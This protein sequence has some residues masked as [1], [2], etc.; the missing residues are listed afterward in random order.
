M[1]SLLE[2]WR[3]D[4]YDHN[5]YDDDDDDEYDDFGL[6]EAQLKFANAY[7]ISIRGQIR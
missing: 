4:T 2:Q 1:K 5:P 6:T 3:K 7:N